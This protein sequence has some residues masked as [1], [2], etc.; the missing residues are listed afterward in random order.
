[1]ELSP[2]IVGQLFGNT[3]L[4]TDWAIIMLDTCGNSTASKKK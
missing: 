1:M 2:L 4:F 3:Q